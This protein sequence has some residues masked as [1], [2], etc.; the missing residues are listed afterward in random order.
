MLGLVLF[1]LINGGLAA[2]AIFILRIYNREKHIWN[3]GKC[4][5]CDIKWA[6]VNASFGM[7]IYK[8]ERCYEYI[9]ITTE[10]DTERGK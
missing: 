3:K 4:S 1:L 10:V 6:F 5:R 7:R 9:A 2:S 8:C